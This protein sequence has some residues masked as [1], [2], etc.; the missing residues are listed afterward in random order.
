MIYLSI[1]ELLEQKIIRAEKNGLP[2]QTNETKYS[3]HGY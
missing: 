2:T 1:S 3:G